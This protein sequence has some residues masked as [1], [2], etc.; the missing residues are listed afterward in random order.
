MALERAFSAAARILFGREIGALPEFGEYLIEMLDPPTVGKSSISGKAVHLS[1]EHYCGRA[2]FADALEIAGKEGKIGAAE[3]MDLDSLL[4]AIGEEF[5]YCGNKNLGL[6]DSVVES[7]MCSDS[8]GILSS[9]NVIA[10]KNVAYCNGV[11]ESES[12]F[13]GTLHGEVSFAMRCGS[14]FYSKRCFEAYLSSSCT[15]LF[16]CFNC[17]NCSDC[18]FCF[19]QAGKRN[20]VGNVELPRE[21][22]LGVKKSVLGFVAGELAEKK[23]FPSLFGLVRTGDGHA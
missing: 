11:R 14:L 13:G 10:S 7:D 19:N 3:A 4:A 15:D 9:Q 20:C 5:H 17:R 22:Y 16:F 23:A 1:R 2:K 12:V 6:C 18:L 21:E 8:S